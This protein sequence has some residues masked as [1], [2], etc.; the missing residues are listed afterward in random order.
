MSTELLTA[1]RRLPLDFVSTPD[2]CE[3][4]NADNVDWSF[5]AVFERA[6]VNVQ[7]TFRDDEKLDG[8]IIV[9]LTDGPVVVMPFSW[10]DHGEKALV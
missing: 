9:G 1:V 6:C 2:V 3:V 4:T 10:T 7:A 8:H 5:D